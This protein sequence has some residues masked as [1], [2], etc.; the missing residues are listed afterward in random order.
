MLKVSNC[1]IWGVFVILVLSLSVANV[2]QA[3]VT[4][5]DLSTAVGIWLF[6]EGSGDSTKDMSSEGNHGELVKS[7]KW[8][9]GK[10]GKALEFN[11]KDNFVKTGQKLLDSRV[12]FSVLCWVNPGKLTGGRI[13]LVGQNDSPEFVSFSNPN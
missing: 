8:V 3:G 12:E 9:T 6:D 5:V 10:F 2:S 1:A 4:E 13:G 7:P 11:G